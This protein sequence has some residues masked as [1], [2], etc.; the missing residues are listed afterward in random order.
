VLIFG[1]TIGG[2]ENDDPDGYRAYS[3]SWFGSPPLWTAEGF[4]NGIQY[5]FDSWHPG[6]VQCALGDGSVRLIRKQVEETLLW[7]VSALRDGTP[8]DLGAL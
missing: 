2:N 7:Q 1:E 4:A 3:N 8:I 6:M 5:Q